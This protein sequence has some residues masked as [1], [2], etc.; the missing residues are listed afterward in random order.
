MLTVDTVSLTVL[1]CQDCQCVGVC[2]APQTS[3]RAHLICASPSS[4]DIE[5]TGTTSAAD[6]NISVLYPAACTTESKASHLHTRQCKFTHALQGDIRGP[7]CC[8]L[9]WSRLQID[10]HPNWQLRLAHAPCTQHAAPLGKEGRAA[11]HC[12]KHTRLTCRSAS[13]CDGLTV[14]H[15]SSCRGGCSCCCV[16]NAASAAASLA[17]NGSNRQPPDLQGK[18]GVWT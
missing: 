11:S 3:C 6:G 18:A 7:S 17:G 4:I 5:C 9:D 8:L 13:S 1:T 15:S 12:I 16:S 2:S 14:P 10:L